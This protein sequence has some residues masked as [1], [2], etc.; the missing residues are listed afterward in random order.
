[1][2]HTLGFLLLFC[3]CAGTLFAQKNTDV[4]RSDEPITWLGLDF[5][6]CR[7]IGDAHQFKDAGEITPNEMRDKYYPSWNQLFINEQKKYD[8]AK[9]VHRSSVNYA[10]NVTDQAN[11]KSGKDVFS[12]DPSNYSRLSRTDI[13]KAVRNY[14]FKGNKGIGMIIFIEGMSKGKEEASGWIAFVDMGKKQI[15]QTGRVT[16]DA[17]GFGF[18]NYWA[19]AFLNLLK[20]ADDI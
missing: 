16:G 8:V 12:N 3:L 13:E 6:M 17:G 10:T 19:K 14:D 15:L 20:K 2:K 4:V 9:Y 1:M 5:T 18:R 11:D 7:F